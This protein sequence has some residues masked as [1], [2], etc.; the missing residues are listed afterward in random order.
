MTKALTVVSLVT[1]ESPLQMNNS[2][3]V[4]VAHIVW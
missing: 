2:S 1:S 3:F 4:N